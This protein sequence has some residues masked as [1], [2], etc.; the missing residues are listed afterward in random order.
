MERQKRVRSDACDP[1]PATDGC[2]VHDHCLSCPLPAC[3][4]D[5]GYVQQRKMVR[6]HLIRWFYDRD[7]SPTDLAEAFN[8]SRRN[9]HYIITRT[10]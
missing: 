5:V 9:V 2:D 8:I 3:I 7:V 10:G 6:N 1:N 4:Y